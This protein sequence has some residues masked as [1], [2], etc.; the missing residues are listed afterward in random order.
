M[1]PPG[2]SPSFAR[3]IE[4]LLRDRDRADPG[5]ASS[6]WGATRTCARMRKPSLGASQAV[7]C[8]ATGGGRRSG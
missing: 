7:P 3:D 6:T 8:R 2:P 4:L 5:A 1:T